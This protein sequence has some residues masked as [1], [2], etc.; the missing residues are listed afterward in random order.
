MATPQRVLA[1]NMHFWVL[2]FV[3]VLLK[4]LFDVTPKPIFF[5]L[6]GASILAIYAYDKY[7]VKQIEKEASEM[8]KSADIFLSE[9]EESERI[10]KEE[11]AK[12]KVAAILRAHINIS[13]SLNFT[14]QALKAKQKADRQRTAANKRVRRHQT[15]PNLKH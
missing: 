7:R 15:E 13:Y 14:I 11:E 9:L 4:I 6:F 8:E 1:E 10:R 5:G 3:L 2:P 12:E